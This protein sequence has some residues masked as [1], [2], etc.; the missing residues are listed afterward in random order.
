MRKRFL[1]LLALPLA[2]LPGA[3]KAASPDE[4]NAYADA[5]M[6]QVQQNATLK[7]GLQ[8]GNWA[9]DRDAHYN[10]CLGAEPDKVRSE[11][12]WREN[13]LRTC[14]CN[15]YADAAMQ[16][17]QA[18]AD[19]KCGL[20]G[21]NWAPTRD[22]HLSWCLQTIANNPGKVASELQWRKDEIEKCK[23]QGGGGNGG[24]GGGGGGGGNVT[25]LLDSDV[26]KKPGGDDQDK[27]G[28]TLAA[29]TPGVTLVGRQDPWFHIKWGGGD[30]WVY[31]GEGYVALKLP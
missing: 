19:L 27:L 17:V 28:E 21:G 18:N 10:W 7:C 15:A 2:T 11:Q 24:G 26:Y 9:T 25:V 16:Q 13:E 5:A 8:G 14:N 23:A 6:Q 20:Q 29:G 30:G 1:V 3:A 22:A 4:C 12:Q 31:S